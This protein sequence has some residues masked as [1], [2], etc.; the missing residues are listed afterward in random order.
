MDPIVIA[1]R[2]SGVA[3]SCAEDGEYRVTDSHGISWSF[4]VNWP[5]Q[6]G[7]AVLEIPTLRSE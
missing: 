6:N 1:S 7:T 4:Y 3:I 5:I 2:K